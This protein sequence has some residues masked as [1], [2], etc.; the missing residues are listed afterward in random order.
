M[1]WAPEYAP[2][3]KAATIHHTADGNNYAAAD[4]PAILRSMYAYHALSRG[5]GDIGYNVI[6]DKFGRLWEGRYGGLASTV[7]GAHAGGFNTGTFGVS[8]L[9]NYDVVDTTQPMVDAVAAIIAWKFSLYNVNPR[10]TVTLTS[11]GGGT[12]KYAAG[13]KVTLPTIFG[14][15]DVGAT[16]CPGQYTYNR[17]NDIRAMVAARSV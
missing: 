14:H 15:R 8:M 10:G 5:W 16:A 3:I 7:I 2:T 6:V 9:G 17:M 12:A 11:G 13:V 4:V 1:G